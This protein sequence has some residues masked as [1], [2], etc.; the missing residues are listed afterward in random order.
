MGFHEFTAS[1]GGNEV[2]IDVCTETGKV[3]DIYTYH[4]AQIIKYNERTWEETNRVKSWKMGQ[5]ALFVHCP[6]TQR[7][8]ILQAMLSEDFL[9]CS[10]DDH[11]KDFALFH[12]MLAYYNLP[13]SCDRAI[14]I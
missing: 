13:S 5:N 3:I 6:P 7:K 12:K 9:V 8:N 2:M 11:E 14:E 10:S 4:D 1:D